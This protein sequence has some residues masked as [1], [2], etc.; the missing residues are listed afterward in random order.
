MRFQVSGFRFAP[1]RLMFAIGLL[2]LVSCSEKNDEWDPYYDWAGR[3]ARWFEQV[4]DSARTAI[5]AAKATYG[6]AWE[7]HCEWRMYKT[8]LKTQD[9]PGALTDSICVHILPRAPKEEAD[10]VSP[11]LTDKVRLHFRGWTMQTEYETATGSREASMA[12]FTQTYYGP[13]NPQTAMPQLMEVKSTIEGY[14]TALQY[15]VRG[16]DW[17]VY[18]P[19]QLAY[20]EKDSEAIP[21][22]STLLFRLNLVAIYRAGTTV[23]DWK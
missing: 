1:L 9:T 17:L 15:M 7:E 16:D 3:N 5:A 19:Q 20:K 18:I 13:F 14:A 21:A 22:Y 4:A 23:P 12:V 2:A 8:L 10:T 6:E 11:V